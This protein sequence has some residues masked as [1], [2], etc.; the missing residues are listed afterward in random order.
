MN[1]TQTIGDQMLA[2][3]AFSQWLGVEILN[4]REG[5]CKT[6]MT[7]RKDM[8][9]G[10]GKAHGG[11]AFSFADSCFGFATNSHGRHAVSIESSVNHI[12]ALNAGDYITAETI[13]DHPTNKLGFHLI[14]VKRG[15]E[16]VA[17]FKGVVYRTQKTW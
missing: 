7:V 2:Q 3:D 16:V 8:L 5:Y 12:Q 14:E 4:C 1:Q 6:A 10:M 11:I 13:V 9:N 17:L 15:Q